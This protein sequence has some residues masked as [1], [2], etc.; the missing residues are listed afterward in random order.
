M[1]IRIS[2]AVPFT[3]ASD[4]QDFVFF[5]ECGMEVDRKVISSPKEIQITPKSLC[6]FDIQIKERFTSSFMNLLQLPGSGHMELNQSHI[7]L[8]LLWE[9]VL[10]DV[11][12]FLVCRKPT[13]KQVLKDGIDH[14]CSRQ[15]LEVCLE[16][17]SR[18]LP[19]PNIQ[20]CVR[21][22]TTPNAKRYQIWLS[23]VTIIL[24][25]FIIM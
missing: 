7:L 22:N 9:P 12:F 19:N 13:A 17:I 6:V 5:Q 11:V 18:K 23:N 2:N 21:S 8:K 3:L 20:D 16:A 10:C 1:T 24:T 4:I 14:H 15:I 25:H